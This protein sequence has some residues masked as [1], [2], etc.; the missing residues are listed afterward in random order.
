[1]LKT[2]NLCG[3]FQ[4]D[5]NKVCLICHE[6]MS[7]SGG[8]AV[9][10]LHCTHRFHKEVSLSDHGKHSCCM[11]QVCRESSISDIRSAERGSS[12]F[13][14]IHD[15]IWNDNNRATIETVC[16]GTGRQHWC[17]N[18]P[19]GVLKVARKL[20]QSLQR[21]GSETAA[22]Q[23]RRL[24]GERRRSA[25]GDISSEKELHT[26]YRQLSLRR[27]RWWRQR[28]IFGKFEGFHASGRHQSCVLRIHDVMLRFM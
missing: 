5:D 23:V 6:D 24:S 20:E 7:K 2:D 8:G 9:Q 28:F 12:S 22:G 11:P 15:A 1:M 14:D 16:R 27:H 10:K 21:R 19:S 18:L 26:P 17:L 4:T 25:D 3:V 13:P